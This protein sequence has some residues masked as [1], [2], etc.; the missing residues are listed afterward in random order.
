MGERNVWVL[1]ACSQNGRD[2]A[3]CEDI[4]SVVF[5]KTSTNLYCN[6]D[7]HCMEHVDYLSL[8]G[9]NVLQE[10]SPIQY[11]QWFLGS[12]GHLW[13]SFIEVRSFNHWLMPST[14][15]SVHPPH[16]WR[17]EFE[18]LQRLRSSSGPTGWLR[19]YNTNGPT[20]VATN[21]SPS[22]GWTLLYSTCTS[23]RSRKMKGPQ[24]WQIFPGQWDR[25]PLED[26]IDIE[27]KHYRWI[28][29]VLIFWPLHTL[30]S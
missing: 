22:I 19:Q 15:R 16:P 26:D 9:S 5:D 8:H 17:V 7:K 25:M 2:S 10:A 3:R 18:D 21:I 6:E 29:P 28:S 11:I 13:T 23:L 27:V 14:L 30:N 1:R 4:Y 24:R 20:E 12:Y